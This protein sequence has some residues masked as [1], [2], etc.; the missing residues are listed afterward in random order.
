MWNYILKLRNKSNLKK[1]M[2]RLE[3]S[4]CFF[5]EDHDIL[6]IILIRIYRMRGFL[7]QS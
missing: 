2:K 5:V 7:W 6:S 3:K 4:V 1:K